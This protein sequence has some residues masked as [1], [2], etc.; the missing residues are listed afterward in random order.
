[1]KNTNIQQF[2]NKIDYSIRLINKNIP[3]DKKIRFHGLRHAHAQGRYFSITGLMSPAKGGKKFNDMTK[4]EQALYQSASRTI[5]QEL[6]HNHVDIV[7]TYI[8]K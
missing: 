8:G 6:G 5:S 7:R 3:D 2:R 1:M 4:S